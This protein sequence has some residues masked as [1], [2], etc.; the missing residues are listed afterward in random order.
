MNV[1]KIW[2]NGTFVDETEAKVSVLA[3]SLHYG[4]AFF[5]GIRAY[6]CSDGTAAVFRLHDHID[7]LYETCKIYRTIIPYTKEEL[8]NAVFEAL[9]INNLKQAYIRP[10]VYH[11]K[12]NLGL[13]SATSPVEVIIA[14]WQW[15]NLLDIDVSNGINVQVSSWRRPAPNTI[16]ALAKA[17][18]NYLSSQ[19]IG[20]EAHVNGYDEAIALDYFGNVSEGS[21]ENIFVVKNGILYTPPISASVLAGITRNTVLALASKEGYTVREQIIPREFLYIADEVFMVGTGAEIL[22]ILSID[23]IPIGAGET[24]EIT[25]KLS[26]LYFKAVVGEVAGY[27]HWITKV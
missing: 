1:G 6:E 5:E 22:P 17:A 25:N 7:R 8:I 14:C 9:R 4:S 23:K 21:G 12:G 13:R 10:L 26:Q 15:A 3:H 16:P 2:M 11:G 24:G 18:G 20:E 27:K 19:L